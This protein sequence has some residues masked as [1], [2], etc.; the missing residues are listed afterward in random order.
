[1]GTKRKCLKTFGVG[2]GKFELR[3]DILP[4]ALTNPFM[5]K[6]RLLTF[7]IKELWEVVPPT[8]FFAVG[9][10]L[11]ILSTNLV[12]ADYLHSFSCR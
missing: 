9:F 10:N 6:S 5:P 11:V 12:L 8:V 7:L 3:P 4:R 2:V 1:V